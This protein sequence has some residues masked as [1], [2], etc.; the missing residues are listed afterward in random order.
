MKLFILSAGFSL[1]IAS[2]VVCAEEP[3]GTEPSLNEFR[4][5]GDS[6]LKERILILNDGRVVRGQLKSRADGYDVILPNGRLFIE[7]HQVRFPAESMRD[8]YQKM[9]KSRPEATPNAHVELAEWC[10]SHRLYGEARRELLD[11]MYLD[12]YRSDAKALL[13]EILKKTSAAGGSADAAVR[14]ENSPPGS[15]STPS[16]NKKTFPAPESASGKSETRSLGG[17]KRSVATQFVRQVQPILSSKCGGANCHG[18]DHTGFQLAAIRSGSTPAIAQ[19]NL[20]AV[21]AQMDVNVPENSALLNALQAGHGGTETPIFRGRD[22]KMQMNVIRDWVQAAAADV[23]PELNSL[24]SDADGSDAADRIE[25]AHLTNTQA[26]AKSGV[27]PAGFRKSESAQ[28][29]QQQDQLLSS[30][31]VSGDS[32][33]SGASASGSSD[34]SGT[35]ESGETG[36]LHENTHHDAARRE[37]SDRRALSEVAVANRNDAFDPQV[38]N[39]KYHAAAME[40]GEHDPRKESR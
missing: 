33:P 28:A 27:K 39:R 40:L 3:A 13:A 26:A 25:P 37:E 10:I 30:V 18:K 4:F 29:D 23:N 16:T 22:G 1:L 20:A 6:A 24:E 31:V 34:R 5:S 17:L 7:T 8:A 2:A 11:A 32:S 21:M 36:E 15:D 12:P 9:R 14:S 38:F 35:D 19:R